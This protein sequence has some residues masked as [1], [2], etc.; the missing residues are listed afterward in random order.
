M[1]QRFCS[2][3]QD[4]Q[5]I[6]IGDIESYL[7]KEVCNVQGT[8]EFARATEKFEKLSIRVSESQLH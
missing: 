8:K 3:Y 4:I 1:D 6:E 5:E 7:S 2:T